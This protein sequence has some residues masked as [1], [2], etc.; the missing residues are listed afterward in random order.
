VADGRREV[1]TESIVE[2]VSQPNEDFHCQHIR[3]SPSITVTTFL[4]STMLHAYENSP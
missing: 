4:E 2:F 3:H 1:E